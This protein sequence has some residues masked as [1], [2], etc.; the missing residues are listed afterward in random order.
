MDTDELR[1]SIWDLLFRSKSAKSID[2]IA[3]IRL[4]DVESVRA[5]VNHEWFTVSDNR[6]SIAYAAPVLQENHNQA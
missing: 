6:V 1:D 4:C 3:A 2:E 5:A